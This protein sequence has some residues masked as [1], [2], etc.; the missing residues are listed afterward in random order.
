MRPMNK[1]KGI[2]NITGGRGR[3]NLN[4]IPHKYTKASCCH[5]LSLIN[6]AIIFMIN[7]FYSL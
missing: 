6:M 1:M 2:K 4:Q 3:K 7:Q 5:S